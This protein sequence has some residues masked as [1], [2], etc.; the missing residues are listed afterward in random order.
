MAV[1]KQLAA[2]KAAEDLLFAEAERAYGRIHEL[3]A[4]YYT[5]W[6]L[7]EAARAGVCPPDMLAAWQVLQAGTAWERAG[8]G[9]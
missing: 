4:F 3:G 6:N 9:G 2:C 5:G 1:S 7:G 8:Y